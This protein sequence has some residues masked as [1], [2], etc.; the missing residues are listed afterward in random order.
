MARK[1]RIQYPGAIYHVMNRGDRREAIFADDADRER[2]LETLAEACQKT[3]WQVHA[4]CLMGNHF[5][6]VIETPQPNL[7]AGMKWLL[8][9]Y[10]SRYNRRHKEFGH[11]FSG[12][13]KALIVDGSGN[14]YLKT[15]CDYVHLNPTRAKVLKPGQALSAF[16]WSSYPQYL[17]APSRRPRWLRVERLL[18][19]WGIPKD[20]AAGRRVFGERME[21]RRGEDLRGEFKRVERGWYL[22]GEEFRQELL[23]QVETRPG[24]SHFGEAVQEAESAQAERLVVAGVKRMGWS[25][26]DLKTHRKGH[27]RKVAL[28]WKLRSQ[29]TMPLAWIAE[30]LSMGTRGHLAWLLQQRRDKPPA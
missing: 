2:L 20:S 22:G 12:R 17:A 7:V 13:Y 29:T 9:T 15:V 27:P 28:A 19:E 6:L 10:T 8:G 24:P 21:W 1:L 16:I 25:E 14:G 3:G 26:A 18:G 30:R 23:E 4:Y 11:L 5:H